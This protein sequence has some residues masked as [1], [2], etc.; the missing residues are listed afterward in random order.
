MSRGSEPGYSPEPNVYV[1]KFASRPGLVIRAKSVSAGDFIRI[2]KLAEN[3]DT[4]WLESSEKLFEDFAKAL[5]GWN[6]CDPGTTKKTPAT[7]RG[8][9]SHDFEFMSEIVLAWMNAIGGISDPL[10]KP[11]SSG[12]PSPEESLPMETLSQNQAS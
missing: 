7:L 2:S 10:E 11:S 12:K 1:L 9:L 4:E 6:L 5:I 3:A 8:I